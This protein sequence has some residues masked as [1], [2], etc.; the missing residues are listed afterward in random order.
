MRNGC[1]CVLADRK[2]RIGEATLG[3]RSVLGINSR[4]ASGGV[5]A[6]VASGSPSRTAMAPAAS[7]MDS[8]EACTRVLHACWN[9][10]FASL[11]SLSVYTQTNKNQKSAKYFGFFC[12]PSQTCN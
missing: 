12:L 10:M 6:I 11:D 3:A 9:A 7:S 4:S 8:P 1:I 5:A 2:E